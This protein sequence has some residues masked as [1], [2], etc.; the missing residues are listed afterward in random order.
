MT[1]YVPDPNWAFY[2]KK[3]PAKDPYKPKRDEKSI[4]IVYNLASE[5]TQ[6]RGT[7]QPKIKKVDFA[8][9]DKAGTQ[10]TRTAVPKFQERRLL[11]ISRWSV[12]KT[13]N[14]YQST[15]AYH[16]IEKSLKKLPEP[17]D[18]AKPSKPKT[19]KKKTPKRQIDR[20]LSKTRKPSQYIHK[21]NVSTTTPKSAR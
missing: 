6:E 7:I 14:P 9:I 11:P 20:L 19:Y 13:D 3:A 12:L 8:H 2:Q 16:Q 18:Q 5:T 15:V 1:T 10:R 21:V 17:T 4:P